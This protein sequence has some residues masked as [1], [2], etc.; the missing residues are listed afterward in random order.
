MLVCRRLTEWKLERIIV[1]ENILHD[2]G[3]ACFS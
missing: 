1:K 2:K 3:V